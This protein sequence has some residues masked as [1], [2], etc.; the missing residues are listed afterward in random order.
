MPANLTP[1][2]LSAEAAFR[3]AKTTEEK[4]QCLVHMLAVIPKHKGT[5]HLQADLKHKLSKLR[6]EDEKKAGSSRR[7]SM[8]NVSREGAGQVVL[9]GAPNAGKS[10]LLAGLTNAEPE[11]ADYAY[12]TT[13]PQ[14]GMIRY[15]NIQI[16]LVD[17]PPVGRDFTPTWVPGVVRN[18][19]VA[20]L[21]VNL[22][23][24]D[25]LE[26]TEYVLSRLV[27]GKIELVAEVADR[28]QPDGMAQVKTRMLCTHADHPDAATVL[29]LVGEV[30]AG[31]FPI[32]TA[33]ASDPATLPPVAEAIFHELK[34][35]RVYTKGRGKEPDRNDPVVLPEGSTVLD[36]AESIHKDLARNLKFA[37]VWGRNKYE[38]MRAPREYRLEDGDVIEL[39]D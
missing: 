27:E 10:S 26:E 23:S 16:Q 22:A 25:V 8:F 39:H 12:T 24:D 4:I 6:N 37:R 5:N 20:L 31:R 21:T 2:Y 35:V 15:E 17:L 14:P 30:F 1:D 18:C 38:G 11:I 28:Y 7:S 13:K 3:A 9:V 33:S 32:W 36:F 19:D 29:E 34:I